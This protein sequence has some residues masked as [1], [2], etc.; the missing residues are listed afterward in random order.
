MTFSADLRIKKNIMI[1]NNYYLLNSEGFFIIFHNSKNFTKFKHKILF[2]NKIK[3]FVIKNRL[4]LNIINKKEEELF[5]NLFVG[6]SGIIFINSQENLF[7]F[8]DFYFTLNS[9]EQLDFLL[10]GIYWRIN[11]RFLTLESIYNIVVALRSF[12]SID[13]F[14]IKNYIIIFQKLNNPLLS[15]VVML[16]HITCNF[17]IYLRLLENNLKCKN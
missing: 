3:S 14:L 17:L 4:F 7:K 16:N 13:D 15:L 9:S 1:K 5:L 6:P 2:Q 10:L 12:N 11:N 8:F